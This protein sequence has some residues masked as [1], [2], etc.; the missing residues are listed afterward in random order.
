MIFDGQ[1]GCRSLI[2]YFKNLFVTMMFPKNSISVYQLSCFNERIC[3]FWSWASFCSSICM[4]DSLFLI[5]PYFQLRFACLDLELHSKYTPDGSESVYDVDQ[6][7]SRK[8]QVIPPLPED[9][10]LCGFN[11]IFAGS[12][13]LLSLLMYILLLLWCKL[14]LEDLLTFFFFF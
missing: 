12:P 11:H 3:N 4:L 5:V 13:I 8:T 9:R 14:H 1:N 2:I 10:F 7:V 6:R